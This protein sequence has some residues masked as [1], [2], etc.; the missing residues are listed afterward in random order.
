MSKKTKIKI[1]SP[2][3]TECAERAQE[4]VGAE[5]ADEN[6]GNGTSSD[7][8]ECEHN[9]TAR[10]ADFSTLD[11]D[12]E[13]NNA[14]CEKSDEKLKAELR[15]YKDRYL[16]ALADLENYR[17]RALKERSELLKYQGEKILFDM[18]EVLD[19]LERALDHADADPHHLKSG[20]EMVFRQFKDA[21]EKWQVK[22]ESAVGTPFDPS[23]QHALSKVPSPDAAP[24]TV[25]NELKKAY[26]YKDRLLRAGEVVV[27]GEMPG[28][29]LDQTL[30][31][32][33]QETHGEST[34]IT[35]EMPDGQGPED[36]N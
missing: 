8:M 19:N 9:A 36:E 2:D 7:S 26:F 1:K 31:E 4:E 33:E 11:E 35:P 20:L 22:G 3:D 23:K 17:K 6:G 21:L 30:H 29:E 16:R 28:Q 18:V 25:I 12:Q 14:V 5:P 32:S 27:A 13:D 34:E 15:D 10:D 24:G